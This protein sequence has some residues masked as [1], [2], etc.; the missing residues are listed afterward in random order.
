MNANR[1]EIAVIL[2]RSGS[3]GSVRSA[4]IE[5][6]N[7]FLAQ[8]VQEPGEALFTLVQFDHE[9]LIDYS[10]YPIEEIPL[11]TEETYQPRGWT[12]LNDAIGRTI[13]DLG[14]ALSLLPEEDRPAHVIVAILT[15]GEENKSTQFSR[16]QIAAMIT[17]QQDMYNWQFIFLS[18]NLKSLQDATAMNIPP[19]NVM[20][21]AANDIGTRS[22]F[23]TIS[24][25][26]ARMR[27]S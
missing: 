14:A 25:N 13:Q 3:M 17:H 8:Q 22:A 16:E 20:A 4:A 6:F 21:Y 24:T 5:G 27:K 9:Y 11:L 23:E 15:D 7:S 10:R 26:V 19:S 1:S 12:A 18:S 2:D